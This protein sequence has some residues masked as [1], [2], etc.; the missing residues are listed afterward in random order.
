VSDDLV[1]LLVDE[2]CG[3]YYEVHLPASVL[4]FTTRALLE[5]RWLDAFRQQIALKHPG[6]VVEHVKVQWLTSSTRP[7]QPQPKE[8]H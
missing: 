3:C 4:D 2:K 8:L 6:R 1:L 5:A 7:T